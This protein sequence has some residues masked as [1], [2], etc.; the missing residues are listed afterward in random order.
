[1]GGTYDPENVVLLTIKQ[2]AAAPKK[3]WKQHG[4]YEDWLAWKTLG[5]QINKKEL[6]KELEILRRKHISK[7]MMCRVVSAE[8]RQKISK[9]NMGKPKSNQHK[10]NLSKAKMGSTPWNKGK[11]FS[12]AAKERMRLA[13]LGTKWSAIRRLAYERSKNE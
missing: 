8:T 11:P 4:K 12:A 1:M 2:H 13:K 3:L 7:G 10:A 6:T 5:G 9:S